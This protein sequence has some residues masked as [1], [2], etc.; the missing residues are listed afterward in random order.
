MYIL[1]FDCVYTEYV[2]FKPRNNT[3]F[4]INFT[5]R[6]YNIVYSVYAMYI[7]LIGEDVHENTFKK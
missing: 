2:Q 4:N 6:V 1:I 3:F 7:Q 5:Q